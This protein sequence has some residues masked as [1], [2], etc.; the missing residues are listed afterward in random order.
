[1]VLCLSI[2]S[3]KVCLIAEQGIS[4]GLHKSLKKL[5]MLEALEKRFYFFVLTDE[6]KP[7]YSLLHY[8][9]NQYL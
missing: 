6:K 8:S 4:L 5:V 1:V 2:K 7:C 3:R 9:L